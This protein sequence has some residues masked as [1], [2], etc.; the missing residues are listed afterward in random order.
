M[1]LSLVPIEGE[2]VISEEEKERRKRRARHIPPEE[3]SRFDNED[4]KQIK[5]FLTLLITLSER[6]HR[7]MEEHAE[8]QG[9]TN[10]YGKHIAKLQAQRQ[11]LFDDPPPAV[12]D[13]IELLQF[14]AMEPW[15]EFEMMIAGIRGEDLKRY[16][17][18]NLK[19][20]ADPFHMRAE[21]DIDGA[22]DEQIELA[23]KCRITPHEIKELVQFHSLESLVKHLIDGRRLMTLDFWNI[24][25]Y[26]L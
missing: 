17:D 5:D 3:L 26:D 2:K 7:D 20:A 19:T 6:F 13:F 12:G 24:S 1:E 21:D 18:T 16:Y 22:Q 11:V 14:F 15:P 23:M 25:Q 9:E 8:D 4:R 10:S